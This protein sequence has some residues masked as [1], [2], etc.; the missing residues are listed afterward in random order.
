MNKQIGNILN[1]NKLSH[2]EKMLKEFHSLRSIDLV[3]FDLK[4]QLFL[5]W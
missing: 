1:W 4:I 2:R 5:E 3:T